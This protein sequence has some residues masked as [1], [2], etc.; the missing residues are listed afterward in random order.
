MNNTYKTLLIVPALALATSA[1]LADDHSGHMYLNPALGY[2]DFDSDRNLD[3]E[4]LM[5][6]GFGYRYDSNWAMEFRVLASEPEIEGTNADIDLLQYNWSALYHLGK[7][8]NFDPFLAFGIGH[9]DFDANGADNK[10]TQLNAGLGFLYHFAERWSFRTEARGLVS[11]SSDTDSMILAGV[12]YAFGQKKKAAPVPMDSDGDGVTDEQDQ[13]PNT[14]VGAAVDAM[15]CALD[16]DGDGVA[17]YKDKCPN[18]PAGRQV[19]QD[20]CK[21]VL[22]KT[23][24][25]SL[26]VNFANNSA[27]VTEAYAGEIQR[28]ADFMKKYGGVSAVIEGHTNSLGNADYNQRLSQRRAEAVVSELVSRHGIAADRLEAKGYGE[29]QLIASDETAEGRKANRRVIAVMKAEVEQ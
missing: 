9:A 19:D 26:Q 17:D 10:D 23:V 4:E 20:G 6:L 14:P 8:G 15:G 24:E 27:V 2:Q 11:D 16:S 18:T 13:C 1:A 21:L 28:V 29:S 12:Q 3:E 7:T 5:S 25:I 22:K